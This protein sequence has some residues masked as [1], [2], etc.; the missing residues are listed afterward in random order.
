[1]WCWR[2]VVAVGLSWTEAVWGIQCAVLCAFDEVDST[3]G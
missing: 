3:G 1:M 2:R